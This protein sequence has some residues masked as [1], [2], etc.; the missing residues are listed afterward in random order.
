MSK[1]IRVRSGGVGF[2]ALLTIVFIT[3][4][5]THNIDWSWWWVLCPMWIIPA[6]TLFLGLSVLIVTVIDNIRK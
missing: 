2:P 5:L 4:K 3:L 6:I 1:E